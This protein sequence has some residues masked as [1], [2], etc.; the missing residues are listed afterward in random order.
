MDL[1]IKGTIMNDDTEL[2]WKRTGQVSWSMMVS[3]EARMENRE[4]MITSTITRPESANSNSMRNNIFGFVI[5]RSRHSLL[6]CL[7]KIIWFLL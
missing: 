4:R 7:Q 2:F 6:C 3:T 1:T 5:I